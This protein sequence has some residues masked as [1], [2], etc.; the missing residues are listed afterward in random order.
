MN[1]NFMYL[2]DKIAES[3]ES[4]MTSISSILSNIATINSR[5]SEITSDISDSNETLSTKLE[6]YKLKTKLLVK[7]AS[8][9]PNWT[10]SFSVSL[11]EAFKATS[12]GYLLV[13]PAVAAKGS[14]Y[15]NGKEILLKNRDSVYDNAADLISIP[16]QEGDTVSSSMEL[17]M[18]YFVPTK[19][20]SVEGF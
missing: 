14:M 6:D 2:E 7:I 3:S 9:V 18:V 13:L 16:M 20:M 11:T 12:N 17:K 10:A 19:E 4:I 15:I 1:K 8:M 5:L